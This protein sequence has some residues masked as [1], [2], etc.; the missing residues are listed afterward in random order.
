MGG[1]LYVD[2][3]NIRLLLYADDIVIMADS[4][5]VLQSMIKRLENYCRNWNLEVNL[6]KSEIMVFRNG[7]R[8][9]REEK[10]MAMR[11]K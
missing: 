2:E 4:V 1:G 7:G 5:N 6:N 3:K 8:R 9:A 11:I 10:W